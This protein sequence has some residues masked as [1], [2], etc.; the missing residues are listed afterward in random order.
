MSCCQKRDAAIWQVFGADILV[1]ASRGHLFFIRSNLW[2]RGLRGTPQITWFPVM[3]CP[4]LL[5]SEQMST[6]QLLPLLTL[7]LLAP[8]SEHVS[9]LALTSPARPSSTSYNSQ[10]HRNTEDSP[11]WWADILFAR[12]C[13]WQKQQQPWTCGV[14]WP[15]FSSS[16]VTG[17]PEGMSLATW[18]LSS[19]H[20]FLQLFTGIWKKSQFKTSSPTEPGKLKVQ[21]WKW[22]KLFHSNHSWRS[23]HFIQRPE[24]KRFA[25]AKVRLCSFNRQTFWDSITQHSV[26]LNVQMAFLLEM[27]WA[28]YVSWL[29]DCATKQHPE[30]YFWKQKFLKKH[31]KFFFFSLL[32][33]RGQVGLEQLPFCWFCPFDL[34]EGLVLD[35]GNIHSPS[36]AEFCCRHHWQFSEHI[37]NCN[38]N[39]YSRLLEILV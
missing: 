22:I 38:E 36:W 37:C 25:I 1:C 15:W 24:H 6:S 13:H 11:P 14:D 21:A 2:L 28:E 39:S 9:C 32:K 30:A 19:T 8:R 3:G 29:H 5:L 17:S 4:P 10:A 27:S 31:P 12:C 16:E 18:V 7:Q 26:M 23:L 34:L 35:P 20:S 33:E